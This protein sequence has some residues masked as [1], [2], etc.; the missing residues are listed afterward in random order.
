MSATGVLLQTERLRLREFGMRDVDRLAALDS[1]PEVM[2]YISRGVATP[3]EVILTKVLPGW[4]AF[5]NQPRPI[6]FW[7]VERLQDDEFIGWLHLRPDLISPPQLEL[8]YRFSRHAWGQGLASEGARALIDMGFGN[9]R[10][11][12]ITAR[13]LIGNRA[14][15][16]V[17]QKCGLAFEGN[18]VYPPGMLPTWSEQERRAVKYSVRRK[19]LAGSC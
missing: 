15:Q 5:Y 19:P 14:S 6:G 12:V 11:D 2:R 8:G 16:R 13:T 17:M 7:A 9:L 3:R 18:F 4:L 1:D 10:C